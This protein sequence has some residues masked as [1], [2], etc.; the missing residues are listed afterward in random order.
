MHA[1]AHT[2]AHAHPHARIHAHAR[3]HARTRKQTH[4]H[5]PAHN[6]MHARTL[7]HTRRHAHTRTHSSKRICTHTST[8]VLMHAHK[9]IRNHRRTH[10]HTHARA[11]AL[12]PPPQKK[13]HTFPLTLTQNLTLTSPIHSACR[14]GCSWTLRWENSAACLPCLI[15][16]KQAHA[17]YSLTIFARSTHRTQKRSFYIRI[18][19]PCEVMFSSIVALKRVFTRKICT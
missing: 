15:P 19:F 4:T 13:A 14:T 18:C 11:R 2:Q 7:I 12:P 9:H 1:H 3:R 5:T 10:I 6:L 16:Q 8:H 17:L